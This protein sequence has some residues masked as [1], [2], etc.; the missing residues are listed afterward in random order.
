MHWYQNL[1][2]I[3]RADI[4]LLM[5]KE[6]LK[7]KRKKLKE[8]PQTENGSLYY[9]SNSITIFIFRLMRFYLKVFNANAEVEMQETRRNPR[10]LLHIKALSRLCVVLI[11]SLKMCRK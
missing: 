1:H 3:S 10:G 5:E 6:L 8:T 4:R 2:A 9:T 7:T 11:Y